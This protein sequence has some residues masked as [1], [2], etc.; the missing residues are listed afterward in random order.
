MAGPALLKTILQFFSSSEAGLVA[1]PTA[2]EVAPGADLW[3]G[4]ESKRP[5]NHSGKDD[6]QAPSGLDGGASSLPLPLPP[7]VW[8]KAADSQGIR[9][10]GSLEDPLAP[11]HSSFGMGKGSGF[12]WSLF[13]GNPMPDTPPCL[14]LH[15]WGLPAP[16][17]P[18]L[19]W[20]P[21]PVPLSA[22]FPTGS[23]R[24]RELGLEGVY[25]EITQP[26]TLSGYLYRAMAPLKLPG[27]KKSKEG[28]CGECGRAA[29][30]V[31]T[32]V[33]LIPRSHRLPAHMV[34]PGESPALLRDGE[35]HRAPGPHREWGPHLP[36]CEQSPGARQPQP[37][38]KVPPAVPPLHAQRACGH[39][40]GKDG[41]CSLLVQWSG[42]AL[43][44]GSVWRAALMGWFILCRFRFILELF[45]TG[46]K[47]QQ[48]GTDRPETL[49]AWASAI[50]KVSQPQPEPSV[51]LVGPWALSPL[52]CCDSSQLR[53]L[54]IL[55]GKH[56]PSLCRGSHPPR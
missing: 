53:T 5:R 7:T 36:G 28:K 38:R 54:F 4:P 22:P 29:G 46:E 16:L 31:P 44:A 14:H 37:Y 48:L 15:E 52:P 30:G 23:P 42:L 12:L 13:S 25:N 34:L 43:G 47:V 39:A 45:L 35:M 27:A 8:P 9:R 6:P 55:C 41:H 1:D 33:P 3:W 49:Q 40:E 21:S 19:W 51:P 32:P 10:C 18:M 17:V 56:P 11:L 2:C 50:G 24:P 26:V 20:V